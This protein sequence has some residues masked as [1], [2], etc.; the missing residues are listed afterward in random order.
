M[1]TDAHKLPVRALVTSC[2][3]SPSTI[4][5]SDLEYLLLVETSQGR[6]TVIARWIQGKVQYSASYHDN[7]GSFLSYGLDDSL[8]RLKQ[9]IYGCINFPIQAPFYCGA[10]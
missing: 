7:N 2:G 3:L 1:L 6:I 10:V 9:Q 5:S 8:V 4:T